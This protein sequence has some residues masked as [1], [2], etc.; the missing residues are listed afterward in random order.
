MEITPHDY[1]RDSL[2]EIYSQFKTHRKVLYQLSTAGGKTFVFSFLSKRWIQEFDCKILILCH[3]EELVKQTVESMNLIGIACETFTAKNKKLTHQLSVYV[4]MIETVNNKLKKDP[5]FFKNIGLVIADECHVQIFSKV[6]DYFPQSK[7]LGCTATPVVLKRIK[8]YKCKFCKTSYDVIQECCEH[9]ADEWSRPFSMSSIYESIVI[10][11]SIGRL[12]EKGNL[13]KEISFIKEYADSDKLITGGDGEITT[14]S[15]DEAYSND[16]AVFNVVLNYSQICKGKKTIIFNGSSK[17]NLMVYK[18]FIEA[19]Y[20]ARMY[21]SVNVEE[22]GCRKDLVD[23]FK[24]EDDAILLNVGC[25]VAGFDCKEVQA[26]ILNVA[27]NSL[28]MFIQA[29]GRGARSTDKIYKDNFILIDGGG[30]IARHG[31]FSDDNRDWE[32]IFYN[33]V[34]KEKAKKQDA[35][36]IQTCMNDECGALYAKSEPSCPICGF[37]IQPSPPQ[38]KSEKLLSEE[39]LVP[40]RKIP[41]PNAKKIHQYTVNKNEDINFAFKIMINQIMDMFVF[42]RVDKQMYI[43]TKNNGD[44][45]KKVKKMINSVYHYLIKQSD[46][47]ASNNRTLAYLYNKVLDK[48]DQYYG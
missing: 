16:D 17:N 3:R 1:Q 42:Y 7:I 33:G 38:E 22:S 25:F 8:F 21:D 12:I 47:S 24:K 31:E 30:N 36:D 11:P 20:N 26:I 40:I 9:E 27:T 45:E 6:F 39:V 35:F 29:V 41:P 5:T 2:N 32:D 46:I 44:L 18:K 14:A 37:V 15:F 13:V 28:S 10:G 19:G 43:N 23:W 34:G 48:L 4:G